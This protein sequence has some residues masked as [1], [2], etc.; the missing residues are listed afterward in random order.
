MRKFVKDNILEIFRTMYEA[1]RN[2]K[3]FMDKKDAESAQIILGDCQ[4]AAIQMGTAIESSEGENF[5]TIGI[6]EEYCETAYEISLSLSEDFNGNKA[7]KRL[8]KLLIK[9][10]NS[11]KNDIKVKL[12][13][14]FLP[15]KASMWDSLESIWQAADEDPDCDAYVV[16]IPYY[17][18]KPDHSFGEYHY[19]G[20]D[21]P[22][23]VPITHY[24]TYDFQKRR[25]DVI[26]IHNPYD[27]NNFVT[28][29]DPR[30]YSSELKKYTECLV[31][32]PYFVLGDLIY[33]SVCINPATVY[34]D[35]IIVQSS[36]SKSMFEKY[37]YQAIGDSVV[38]HQ[39]DKKFLPLGSPKIDKIIHAQKS[40]YN[41]PDEW[42]DLIQ[43][44]MVVLY[45]TGVSGVLNGNEKELTKLKNTISFF[46]SREDVVLWWRPHPLFKATISSM[47]SELM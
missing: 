24:D 30:F 15:Y 19:E 29:V 35:K 9:A 21:F 13:V 16:P 6:L 5:I 2:I 38:N 33:K 40:M 11:V 25:P 20:V 28:S 26:Y 41:L 32:I 31:Y 39:K 7:Q 45:N 12:E 47:R 34:A 44:K 17:D 36:K 22:E 18:R 43:N 4:N 23:Y 8:D 37:Y 3:K 10:E 14:V 46:K 1:H 27:G 42:A